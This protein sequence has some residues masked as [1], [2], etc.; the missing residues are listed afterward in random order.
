[1]NLFVRFDLSL[2]MDL[3]D[4]VNIWILAILG[5]RNSQKMHSLIGI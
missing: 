4:C 1:M 5:D 3:V 2:R